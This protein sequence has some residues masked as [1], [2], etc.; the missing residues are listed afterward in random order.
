MAFPLRSD[1]AASYPDASAAD[2]E[3]QVMHDDVHGLANS[4][5]GAY[6]T[7][8]AGGFVGTIEDWL[9]QVG[10]AAVVADGDKGDI[11]VSGSGA[12]WTADPDAVVKMAGDQTVAGTKTFSASPI[13]PTPTTDF[14]AA[15]K[16][17]AD[18]VGGGGSAELL[19]STTY[20]PA[21]LATH[22]STSSTFTDADA[23]NLVVTFTAPASGS[24]DVFLEAVADNAAS[25]TQKWNLRDSVGDVAGS[26]TRVMGTGSASLQARMSATIPV[27]GLTSGTSYTF[28]WGI[29]RE[30]GTG[31]CRFFS[32]DVVGPTIMR[33]RAT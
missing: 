28:K 20:D 18:S 6:Q 30:A 16:A 24:V 19:A 32:G 23:T 1:I 7:A 29:A 33:V 10:A 27:S 13:V 25:V 4:V 2:A 5:N 9:D 12:T 26:D 31:T 22:S 17:Y 14:Q 11:T 3:H 21:T 8:V 15:T